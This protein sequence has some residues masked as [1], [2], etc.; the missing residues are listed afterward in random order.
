MSYPYAVLVRKNINTNIKPLRLIDFFDF[1]LQENTSEKCKRR[2]HAIICMHNLDPGH[3]ISR[4]V[5]L[6]GHLHCENKL[7]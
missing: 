2:Q 3:F 4:I 5:E 7:M 6:G 1:Y